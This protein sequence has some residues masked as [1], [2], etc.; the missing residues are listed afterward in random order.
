MLLARLLGAIDYSMVAIG[1]AIG[2]FVVPLLDMG[3]AKTFV[4]DAVAM[5]DT[6]SVGKLS[7]DNFNIRI[8]VFLVISLTL[9]IVCALY[10]DDPV[11]AIS[12]ALLSLWAGII[13]LYPTSWFDYYY[14]T[15]YQNLSVMVERMIVIL[16]ISMLLVSGWNGSLVFLVSV[17]LF[18]LRMASIVFQVRLW[19]KG[20]TE[21]KYKY[22]IKWPK[23][24]APGINIHFTV[25]LLSN[26]MLVYGNQLILGHTGDV[27]GLSAYSFSFQLISLILL[28]QVQAIRILN[29]DI[30]DNSQL[31]SGNRL[32][33][34]LGAHIAFLAV[35]SAILA[36]A[37]YIFST[38]IP[39]LLDD[40]RFTRAGEF[41]PLLCAW[42]VIVGAGQ[43]IT[44]YL[45]EI[46]QER[47]H[48]SVS[49]IGGIS[50]LLL[51]LLLVPEY[52][53]IAVPSI[54]IVVHSLTIGAY[55]ARVL[56]VSRVSDG[57]VA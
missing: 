5:A 8:T 15:V 55:F 26:A 18:T 14:K 33:M 47:Y 2:G 42:V 13:G 36:F 51:G 11:T 28:F 48:L 45:L 7:N 16:S 1:L 27:V 3:S 46:K 9:I 40:A 35:V 57:G 41:M 37:V 32:I 50:A 52:G 17:L 23:R 34:H 49:V 30:T 54:L 12:V 56:Y 38:Y 44:Q 53:A 22:E 19:R 25:A 10:F 21:E 24:E 20:Y 29:R 31:F 4:R 39:L 6:S 43:V